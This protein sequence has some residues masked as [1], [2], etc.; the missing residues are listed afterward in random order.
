[1]GTLGVLDQLWSRND[2]SAEEYVTCLRSLLEKNGGAIRLPK[3]EI[4]SR[5]NEI[6]D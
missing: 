6:S 4:L 2:I 1:M 3:A 5:I